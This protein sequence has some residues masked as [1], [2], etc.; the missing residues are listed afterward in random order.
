MKGFS[1][2]TSSL[3]ATAGKRSASANASP[4]LRRS[5]RLRLRLLTGACLL[6]GIAIA[7]RVLPQL[8][9]TPLSSGSSA[10]LLGYLLSGIPNGLWLWQSLALVLSA[11]SVWMLISVAYR[12][13]RWLPRLGMIAAALAMQPLYQDLRD[14]GVVWLALFFLS[15]SILLHDRQIHYG[16]GLMLAVAIL[17]Q[18]SAAAALAC[19]LWRRRFVYALSAIASVAV[20]TTASWLLYGVPIIGNPLELIR[21]LAMSNW[22]LWHSAGLNGP[23]AVIAAAMDATLLILL[24]VCSPSFS[25][26]I[27][28][29]LD[30]LIAGLCIV[31]FIPSAEVGQHLLLLAC[32]LLMAGIVTEK[33]AEAAA[34][35]RF[36]SLERWAAVFA[37]AS[38]LGTIVSVIPFSAR[39]EALISLLSVKLLFIPVCLLA[40]RLSK[41]Q[42][43]RTVRISDYRLRREPI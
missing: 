8:F 24:V 18:P 4:P 13:K 27:R 3:P 40:W 21:V 32:Y 2:H 39:L 34:S 6:L 37:V 1:V 7:C 11:A 15:L 25:Q 29:R 26:S 36:A 23:Y 9:N 5:A 35:L 10:H 22:T 28:N 16:A 43:S 17:L 42:R 12:G 20:M 41:H 31:W 30:Y 33:Y 19:F 14:F 38:Y